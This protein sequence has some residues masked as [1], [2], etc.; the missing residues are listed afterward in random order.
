MK[1]YEEYACGCVSKIDS[2]RNLPGY[3]P[4]H[5]SDRRYVHPARGMGFA[6]EAVNKLADAKA[7][8]E[9]TSK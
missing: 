2:K 5:G 4:T 6:Q 8:K 1:Y 3:C 9:R 7:E